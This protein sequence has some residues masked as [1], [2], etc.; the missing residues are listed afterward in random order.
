[1]GRL[2]V[3]PASWL[4]ARLAASARCWHATKRAA[5][6]TAA[7]QRPRRAGALRALRRA[8]CQRAERAQ[9]GRAALLQR[10][11]RPAR[12]R[13]AVPK[14]GRVRIARRRAITGCSRATRARR[15]RSGSRCAIST[16]TASRWR[17][18]S[19][20]PRWSTATRSTSAPTGS[21]FFRGVCAAPISRLAH[22][23]FT[24]LL[25]NLRD[26]FNLQLS[27]ACVRSTSLADHRC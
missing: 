2:I 21:D 18:C 15:I 6:P 12:D 13:A 24:A 10:G 5:P 1:M 17:R 23:A 7:P 4:L 25:R 16:S 27:R 14:S 22:G 11:A 19:S 9:R 20:A 8:T 26:L 3:R